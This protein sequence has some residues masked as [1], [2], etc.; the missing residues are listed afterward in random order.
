MKFPGFVFQ[1]LLA[2]GLI[3]FRAGAETAYNG[4]WSDRPVLLAIDMSGAA[5]GSDDEIVLQRAVADAAA[6]WNGVIGRPFFQLLPPGNVP[7][8]S[9]NGVNEIY[10]SSAMAGG[11]FFA[12]AAIERDDSFR[13]VES[14]I[15]LNPSHQ[16][17]YYH[18]PLRHETNGDRIPDLYRVAL[19]EMGHIVGFAHAEPETSPSVM[20]SHMSDV[21]DFTAEDLRDA[22]VIVANLFHKNAPQFTSPR[23]FRSDARVGEFMLRGVGRPFF[24]SVVTLKI[25]P[26]SGARSYHLRIRDVWKRRVPLAAGLNRLQFFYRLPDHTIVRFA[27]RLI[28]AR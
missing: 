12:A 20:R 15:D 17:F 22:K 16:W 14:D 8:A 19:H 10:F 3:I 6:R 28:R 7:P 5:A 1:L 25:T 21:D 24:I 13:R 23:R 18:G 26:G 2:A 9:E 27:T 4:T 11:P